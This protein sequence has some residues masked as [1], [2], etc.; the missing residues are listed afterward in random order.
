[1]KGET[2]RIR[3]PFLDLPGGGEIIILD[4]PVVCHDVYLGGLEPLVTHQFLDAG[5]GHIC[6]EQVVGE[7]MPELM[8]GEL[9]PGQLA[10]MHQAF[11]DGSGGQTLQ[12]IAEKNVFAGDARTEEQV[13]AKG[14][15]GLEGKIDR[16]LPGAFAAHQHSREV[17]F[18]IQ[19]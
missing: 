1:M 16:T 9:Q 6:V 8:A 13:F 17:F 10:I 4:L 12:L 19:V 2:A 18:Q 14:E 7:R 3:L 15:G 5:D 11:M